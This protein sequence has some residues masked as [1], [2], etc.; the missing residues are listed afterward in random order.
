[1]NGNKR[2]IV[3]EKNSERNSKFLELMRK[4]SHELNPLNYSKYQKL[5][6]NIALLPFFFGTFFGSKT[7]ISKAANTMATMTKQQAIEE[8]SVPKFQPKQFPDLPENHPAYG[9]TETLY[10]GGIIKGYPDGTVGVDKNVTRAEFATMLCN[11]FGINASQYA[12]VS[13]P[14]KDVKKSDWFYKYVAAAYENK[15]IKGYPDGTFGPQKKVTKAEALTMIDNAGVKYNGWT[16]DQTGHTFADVKPTDWF[17]KYIRTAV[18]HGAVDPNN[19]YLVKKTSNGTLILPNNPSL[20]GQDIIFLYKIAPDKIKD[21]DGDGLT[22]LNEIEKG[23]N[24]LNPDTDEDGLSDGVDKNPRLGVIFVNTEL[25]EDAPENLKNYEMFKID[26]NELEK[27]FGNYNGNIDTKKVY[28]HTLRELIERDNSPEKVWITNNPNT[29]MA[30][31]YNN[32]FLKVVEK[33]IDEYVEKKYPKGPILL[34]DVYTYF[35]NIIFKKYKELNPN[36]PFFDYNCGQK[37]FWITNAMNYMFNKYYGREFIIKDGNTEYRAKDLYAS[38]STASITIAHYNNGNFSHD[39]FF[40]GY[41]HANIKIFSPNKVFY[42]TNLGPTSK[43][44]AIPR[45][46]FFEIRDYYSDWDKY[47]ANN[48]LNVM[49]SQTN[50][51]ENYRKDLMKNVETVEYDPYEFLL[52]NSGKPKNFEIYTDWNTYKKMNSPLYN[53]KMNDINPLIRVLSSI[54]KL[55]KGNYFI[56]SDDNTGKY[57][58]TKVS[59]KI[60]K[61]FK[62][63]YPNNPYQPDVSSAIR[64]IYS[65][66]Q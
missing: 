15:L 40:N 25:N 27:Y 30:R 3:G 55:E 7:A 18:D 31:L 11:Q 58:I 59:G 47:I 36:V 2:S 14:F 9:A 23:L 56:L 41:N 17:Y 21:P 66:H 24:P 38:D 51:I 48:H 16:L 45:G 62:E 1:M 65:Q 49:I 46:P 13:I 32:G 44:Y 12:N 39:P 63:Q 64:T 22:T 53:G 35:G 37:D 20:R 6:M 26:E 33:N 60:I 28:L 10:Y 19:L 52:F 61:S 43:I 54:D 4:F 50:E 42:T 57:F 5:A 34:D 8:L 29:T